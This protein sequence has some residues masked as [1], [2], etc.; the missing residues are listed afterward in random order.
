MNILPETYFKCLSDE[1][2]LRCLLLV[3]Q[4]HQLCVCELSQALNLAQPKISRHLTLLRH[5]QILQDIRLGQWVYY[6]LH[7]NLPEWSK[8]IVAI[9]AKTAYEN[10][11]YQQDVIRLQALKINSPYC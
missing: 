1:T 9:S 3:Y 5:H 4:Y 11:L 6:Q 2:R 7:P 8:E 10:K